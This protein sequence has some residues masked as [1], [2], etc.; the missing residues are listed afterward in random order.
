M[1]QHVIYSIVRSMIQSVML[2]KYV[3]TLLLSGLV[4]L[5]GAGASAASPLDENYTTLPLKQTKA[6]GTLIFSDC[7][8]YA[9]KTGIL[10]EGTVKPGKGRVYYY[11]VN[12]T[13]G[14]AR[15]LVYALSDKKQSLTVTR[16]VKGD[17]S[18]SYIPTGASL[19]FREAVEPYG[20]PETVTLKDKNKV[21]L[22]DDGK[23][24]IKE[25]DLV[26]G[27]VEVET[28]APVT[29]GVA[30]VPDGSD[31]DVK[32]ALDLALPLPPDSHEM[33]GTFARDIYVE[34]DPWDFAKGPAALS[35]GNSIPFQK[36]MDEM[37]RVERENTGD[38]G[39][40]YHI[41]FRSKGEGRYNLY[42]NAQGGV[43]LGTFQ[44]GQNEKLLRTYRTDGKLGGRWFGNG[45]EDDYI[46]CGTWEAGKDLY[47]RF[48]P[49]GATYLPIRFLL[50]PEKDHK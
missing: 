43:Y 14:P 22:Y 45:T 44:I 27:M 21:V 42:I 46:S 50:V 15:V 35:I 5:G 32:K 3:K 9:D 24:G 4:L 36:G 37:S 30:I 7:P 41:T 12:E 31:T 8:E 17:A 39:V 18:S 49:A 2:K 16:R 11:H 34:N 25:E 23:E 48:I 6:E 29:M 10:Y 47:I 19:S 13:G 26:S 38:Y 1:L 20:K 28:K 33:R 40:T